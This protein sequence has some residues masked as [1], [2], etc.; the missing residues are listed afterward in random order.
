MTPPSNKPVAREHFKSLD[1]WR[2]V[3]AILVAVH[4]FLLFSNNQFNGKIFHSLYLCVDFFFVLSGFVITYNYNNRI[5]NISDLKSYAIKRIGRVWPLH[6]ALMFALLALIMTVK[7]F[8]IPS[9]YTIGASPTTYDLRK[10]SLVLLLTNSYGFFS[11]G[12]N[13]PSWSISAELCSYIVFAFAF[14]R[15]AKLQYI[16][17]ITI[18]SAAFTVGLSNDH[19]NLTANFGAFRCLWGF[20]MGSIC[21][22]IYDRYQVALR[23]ASSILFAIAELSIL[24]LIVCMLN[25]S[26]TMQGNTTAISYLAPIIFPVAVLI[27]AFERGLVSKFL[28]MK[29]LIYFGNLSY[30]IYMVHWIVLLALSSAN[31]IYK[32]KQHLPAYDAVPMWGHLYWKWNLME[33]GEFF[34]F[35]CLF[36]ILV[37]LISHVTYHMIEVPFRDM[38]SRFVSNIKKN[39]SI[40]LISQ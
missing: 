23:K 30:S 27:F 6:V 22:F 37:V 1:S 16:V 31:Y 40:G 12:W 10:F 35:L 29:F 17:L 14:M 7:H 4:H 3:C 26:V 15:R 38:A 34:Q 9:P 19:M 21:F 36:L 18:I 33:N 13:L 8:N 25:F 11:G 28:K 20:G 2:G 39:K 32:L 24:G 5:A